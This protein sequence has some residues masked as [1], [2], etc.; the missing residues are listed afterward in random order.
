MLTQNEKREALEKIREAVVAASRIMTGAVEIGAK[1]EAKSSPRDLVTAYDKA[2]EEYL[3]GALGHA[4]P[5][6]KFL[7]EEGH[8]AF[9]AEGLL[10]IIDPIDG[11]ANFV[12]G[13]G[14]SAISVALTEDGKV[15]VGVVYNPYREEYY[16]AAEGLGAFLNGKPISVSEQGF[17][18]GLCL[19]GSAPY[20]EEYHEMTVTGVW[21][22]LKAGADVR[23]L[24]SAALDLCLVARGAAEAFFEAILRPW[25]Y[26]AASLIVTEAGGTVTDRE[27]KPLPLDRP[28]FV[29]A[30]CPAAWKDLL[31]VVGR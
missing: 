19:F 17:G 25:D 5:R 30:A 2:V 1:T 27:G 10:F 11:T 13:L 21:R 23:R 18:G 29:M 26:A 22:A 3:V 20:D 15:K 14:Q 8:G 16:E 7:G 4:F 6:A 24:G 9:S 31:H 28:S 12:R